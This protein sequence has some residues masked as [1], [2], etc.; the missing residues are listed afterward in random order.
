MKKSLLKNK[1]QFIMILAIILLSSVLSF[2]NFNLFYIVITIYSIVICFIIFIIVLNT[3]QIVANNYYIFLGIAFGFVGFFE[4]THTL[5]YLGIE[6]L[7]ILTGENSAQ[8]WYLGRFTQALALLVSFFFTNKKLN[9]KWLITFFSIYSLLFLS[10]ILYWKIPVF[11]YIPEL[12]IRGYQIQN[13]YIIIAILI[14]T[15]LFLSRRRLTFSDFHYDNMASAIIFFII[16]ELFFILPASLYDFSNV[17]GH[18]TRLLSFYFIYRSAVLSGLKE[19]YNTIFYKLTQSNKKLSDL[20]QIL[21]IVKNIHETINV[22]LELNTLFEK[23]VNILIQKE[24]Y[25]MAFIGE[26][27]E[28]SSEIKIKSSVGISSDFLKKEKLDLKKDD[29]AVVQAIKKRRIIK[30]DNPQSVLNIFDKTDNNIHNSLIALPINYDNNLYGVLVITS[31]RDNAF[32]ERVVELL[33]KITQNL[34]IAI[35]RYFTQQQI[36]YMSFHDQ[37][38]GLYNRNFFNEE[39][40]RL[41]TSRKLPISIIITDFNDLKYINDSYG[42]KIGD[43][44]LK[45]YAQILKKNSRQEDIIARWGGDEFVILLPNTDENLT[46]KLL[47]RLKNA[48]ENVE[49]KGEKMSIAFGYAIKASPDQDIEETFRQADQNMYE[50]KKLMKNNYRENQM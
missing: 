21:N 49:I 31:Y 35:T 16:S 10:T 20:N 38:T 50:N 28:E 48:V 5:S 19:P 36:R 37:L 46:E 39:I 47:E 4:F 24:D 42:H 41:D 29:N 18:I 17:F 7:P 2:Y 8:I 22:N 9:I 25:Q 44:F 13:T 6:V 40:N 43:K 34:G 45:T 33:N 15:L 32:N 23:I 3:H 30:D 27:L 14:I 12:N 1:L 11:N 26:Y